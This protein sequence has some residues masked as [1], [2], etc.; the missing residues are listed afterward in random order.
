M[1]KRINICI[2]WTSFFAMLSACS[3]TIDESTVFYPNQE[4]RRPVSDTLTLDHESRLPPSVS[5]N[6]FRLETDFGTIAVTLA[7]TGSDRLIVHC[8]GNAADRKTGGVSYLSN[9]VGF[10]DVL[11]FDYPAYGDSEGAISV[12]DFA[13]ANAAVAQYVNSLN[14]EMRVVWGQ[15]LGG[16]VCGELSQS[17][18][19]LDA[20]IFETSASNARA[21]A[22]VWVPWY[23]K[24]FMRVKIDTDLA[25]YDNV[26]I[27]KTFAG[28]ILVL[29][30][31]KDEVLPV[32][33]SR[34]LATR[35]RTAGGNV[36][37]LEFSG[38]THMSVPRHSDF[39]YQVDQFFQSLE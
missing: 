1:G 9:L 28:K 2:L 11:L 29:G 19:N 7:G 8:G 31:E 34:E 5:L 39:E 20:I 24:P 25:T 33:L 23:V 30:A 15:S 21:V 35:I 4:N 3:Q 16:F 36:T 22:K 17:V 10:G 26:E 32:K 14:Y 18:A 38:A 37:Y 13:K 27:A 6:H 12:Q